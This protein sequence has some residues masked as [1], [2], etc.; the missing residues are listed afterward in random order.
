MDGVHTDSTLPRTQPYQHPCPAPTTAPPA[1]A[2]PSRT[3]S[4]DLNASKKSVAACA[5]ARSCMCILPPHSRITPMMRGWGIAERIAS[6]FC[7][8]RKRGGGP[9]GWVDGH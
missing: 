3:S 4:Y 2:P 1:L 6:A 9:G 5:Q 8:S 7:G